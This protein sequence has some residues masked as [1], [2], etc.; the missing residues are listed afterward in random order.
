VKKVNYFTII[1]LVG[2]AVV[3]NGKMK[4]KLSSDIYNQEIESFGD[5]NY[6]S[7]LKLELS[8]EV[9]APG[10]MME[11][12]KGMMLLGILADVSFPFGDE[13]TSS[14]ND[15]FK[16]IAGTAWS[17]HAVFSYLINAAFLFELRA[18][19]INFGTQTEEGSESGFTYK[20]EDTFSQIPILLGG[21]YL[22]ATKGSFKPYI[23]LALAVFFQTWAVNWQETF[24][25]GEPYNLDQSFT[26][27]AFG[28]VP[29]LGFYYI[30]S[31]LML[32]AVVEYAFIFSNLPKYED[33]GQTYE[34]DVKAKYLSVLLGISFPLGGK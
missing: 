25:F 16:H 27:T 9:T 11:F 23:G 13:T 26:N 32:H 17:V 5:H 22:F 30:L 1:I 15:G 20:Y 10:G 14:G 31:S 18:G 24:S 28:I 6:V 3:V 12:Y 29:G 7:N 8:P 19:Y 4:L 2:F 33:G 34:S 21:Y